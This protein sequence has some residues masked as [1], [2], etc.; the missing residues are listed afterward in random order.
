MDLI[1]SLK[2]NEAIKDFIT[3]SLIE[4]VGDTRTVEKVLRVMADVTRTLVK[5]ATE[6]PQ[7]G[8]KGKKTPSIFFPQ[9]EY[10]QREPRRPLKS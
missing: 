8:T 9:K 6:M 10:C 1:E 2:K 4:K 5:R 7:S 3:K